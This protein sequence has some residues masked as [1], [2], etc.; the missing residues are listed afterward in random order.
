MFPREVINQSTQYHDT[1]ALTFNFPMSDSL[2]LAIC[3]VSFM[4]SANLLRLGHIV[5][6]T[7][8]IEIPK[9]DL[10][11]NLLANEANII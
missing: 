2:K 5:I 1:M 7:T 10:F 3:Q 6:T 11:S 8:F 9:Y 4:Q